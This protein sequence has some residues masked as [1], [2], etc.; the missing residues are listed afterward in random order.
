MNYLVI[1]NTGKKVQND[2]DLLVDVVVFVVGTGVGHGI[3]VE[4]V[5]VSHYIETIATLKQGKTT[6]T[7]SKP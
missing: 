4:I 1:T 6:C 5:G 3:T 2:L 7:L